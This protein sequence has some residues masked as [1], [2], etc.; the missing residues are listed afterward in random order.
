MRRSIRLR[1]ACACALLFVGAVGCGDGEPAKVADQ[2]LAGSEGAPECPIEPIA[3]AGGDVLDGDLVIASV[4]DAAAAEHL[5]EVSGTLRIAP[6]Y[7]GVLFLPNLVRVGKD[8][9][10]EGHVVAGAPEAEWAR[11]TELRLP[12]LTHVGGQLFV[13]LTGALTETDLRKLETVGERVYYMRNLALRRIGLDLLQNAAVGIQASPQA[14]SCEID[15]VCAQVGGG[16]SCG[17]QYS[18]PNCT[19]EPRCGRLEPNCPAWHAGG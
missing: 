6:T 3:A 5:S 2:G 1:R 15:A 12:N 17:S 11:I 19:C 9:H 10:V 4:A 18:D 7:P 14:A 16:T 13:Y 8:V